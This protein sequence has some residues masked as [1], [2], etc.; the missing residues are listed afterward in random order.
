MDETKKTNKG[1]KKAMLAIQK[2]MDSAKKTSENPYFHSRYSDLPSVNAA[3][4]DA[5]KKANTFLLIEQICYTNYKNLEVR[6]LVVK[7]KQGNIIKTYDVNI[8]LVGVS[9]LITEPESGEFEE[10]SLELRPAEDTPQAVGSTISY[11]RRYSLLSRFNISS[12][13]DDGNA[14]SGKK[15]PQ[16]QLPKNPPPAVQNQGQKPAATPPPTKTPAK[17]PAVPTPT[18]EAQKAKGLIIEPEVEML[19]SLL[20]EKG[21]PKEVFIV[22]L[23]KIYGIKNPWNIKAGDM[24]KKV[25]DFIQGSP[26][27]IYKKPEVAVMPERQPG[28]DRDESEPLLDMDSYKDP[29]GLV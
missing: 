25:V 12:E 13:D 1:L 14:G 16:G 26:E 29:R 17:A 27:K 3:I 8:P 5:M 11:I 15:E 2:V 18:A 6:P 20:E 22:W 24:Y 23:L 21:I 19:T 9:T 7:D 4:R 10:S 28:E